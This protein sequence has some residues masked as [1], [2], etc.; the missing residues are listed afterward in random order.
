MEARIR[1]AVRPLLLSHEIQWWSD[2]M[3]G[4]ESYA[5]RGP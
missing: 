1:V 4:L 5:L 3:R 2:P